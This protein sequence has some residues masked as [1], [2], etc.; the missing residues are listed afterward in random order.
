MYLQLLY[1]HLSTFNYLFDELSFTR[2]LCY[3]YIQWPNLCILNAS[4]WLILF[5]CRSHTHIVFNLRTLYPGKFRPP[6]SDLQILSI[7]MQYLTYAH[8]IR[9]SLDLL[10]GLLVLNTHTFSANK[11]KRPFL[12]RPK[13]DN[14]RRNYSMVSLREMSPGGSRT[15]KPWIY[16][17]I[18]CWLRTLARCL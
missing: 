11:T 5:L 15:Q 7:H 14:S 17:H 8:C 12:N 3:L 13:G 18:F 2:W 10:S 6:R 1:I 4:L 16:S 9:A